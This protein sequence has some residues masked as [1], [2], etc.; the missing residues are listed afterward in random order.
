MYIHMM[1]ELNEEKLGEVQGKKGKYKLAGAYFNTYLSITE[2]TGVEK[3]SNTIG[4]H[5]Q[6]TSLH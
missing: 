1:T 3:I 5:N 6:P 4:Q 2:R